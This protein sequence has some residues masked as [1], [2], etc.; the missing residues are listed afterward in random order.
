M[1]T[2]T[3]R[4]QARPGSPA[5]SRPHSSKPGRVGQDRVEQDEI[6]SLRLDELE[7]RR[8]PVGGED[9]EAV[10][11]QLLGEERPRGLLV[12]D[13]QDGFPH[14]GDASNAHPAEPDVLSHGTVST[15]AAMQSFAKPSGSPTPSRS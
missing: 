6:G 13:D 10:V 2:G 3:S 14:A 11:A 5:R 15:P 4:F 12:L 7:R 1:I 9:L 8:G